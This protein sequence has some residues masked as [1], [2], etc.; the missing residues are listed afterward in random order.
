[1]FLEYAN[2][3]GNYYGTPKSY[4]EQT[5][6]MGIDVLLEIDTQGALAVKESFDDG[7]FIFLMPPSLD[8]LKNRIIGRG[9]ETEET[10]NKRFGAAAAEIKLAEKY[11]YAVINEN[12]NDAVELIE[13]IIKAEKCKIQRIKDNILVLQEVK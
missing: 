4:V 11:H 6:E 13:S 8:E 5:L 3:Y 10:L 1:N 12:I 2:V 7:V 9:S